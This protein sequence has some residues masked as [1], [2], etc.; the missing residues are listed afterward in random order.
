MMVW[1]G[2]GYGADLDVV[3]SGCVGDHHVGT[4]CGGPTEE[5]DGPPIKRAGDDQAGQSY[6]PTSIQQPGRIQAH[7]TRVYS[8]KCLERLS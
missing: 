5:S 7:P 3:R 4:G 1:E 8:P 2:I 6:A